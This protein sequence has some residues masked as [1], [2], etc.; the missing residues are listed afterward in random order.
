MRN[1]GQEVITMAVCCLDDFF[2]ICRQFF[3]D[4]STEILGFVNNFFGFVDEI[5]WI[6]CVVRV[7]RPERPRGAKDEV[8][9]ARRATN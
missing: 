7:T 2:G 4:L 1:D 6:C 5:F 3:L 8:K 9:V